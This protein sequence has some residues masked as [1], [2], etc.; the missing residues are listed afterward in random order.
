MPI[1]RAVGVAMKPERCSVWI[2]RTRSGRSSSIGS[3]RSSS[4]AYPNVASTRALAYTIVPRSSTATIALGEASSTSRKRCSLSARSCSAPFRAEISATIAPTRRRPSA[5][6]EDRPISTG[7]SVPSRRR[8]GGLARVPSPSTPASRDTGSDD[9]RES[10]GCCRGRAVQQAI[11][12][13]RRARTRTSRR[14]GC[15]RMRSAHS[16]RPAGFR[17]DPSR[18]DSRTRRGAGSAGQAD[19]SQRWSD[20]A[21]RRLGRRPHRAV[22]DGCPRTRSEDPCLARADV[23]GILVA[24]SSAAVNQWSSPEAPPRVPSPRRSQRR[25]MAA[26]AGRRGVDGR[27]GTQVRGEPRN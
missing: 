10:A 19:P 12:S 3:P 11:Q 24:T 16:P 8:A 9:R 21:T 13:A 23:G 5:S 4:G 2:S 7:N 27:Q 17:S 20:R 1:G 6:N 18:P 25:R 15:S 26:G 14:H 22:C